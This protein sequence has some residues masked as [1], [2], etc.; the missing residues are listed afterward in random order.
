MFIER[1]KKEDLNEFFYI[2]VSSMHI[3]KYFDEKEEHL[4]ITIKFGETV[5]NEIMYDFSSTYAD[6]KWRKFL[7]EKFG[8]EYKTAYSEFLDIYKK[9]MINLLTDTTI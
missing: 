5:K 1:L 4:Y 3:S 8:E 9:D 2:N 7:Y 6:V